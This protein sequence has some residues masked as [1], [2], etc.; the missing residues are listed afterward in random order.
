MPPNLPD[1][2]GTAKLTPSASSDRK[3]AF[4]AL[5]YRERRRGQLDFSGLGDINLETVLAAIA[6]VSTAIA[7]LVDRYV[8]RRT[9]LVYRVQV[10]ARIGVYPGT[11]KTHR[12]V[13]VE[14]RHQGVVVEDPSIVLLR[15]DNAG[16]MDI[17]SHDMH[18]KVAFAFPDR[19]IVGL[20]VTEAKPKSLGEMLQRR[21]VPDHY[22]DTSKLV[23]PPIAINRGDHFKFL[24]VL[25][26]T[27][28]GVTHSGYLAGGSTGGGVYHEPRPRGPGRRTLIFGALSLVL[29]GA[30]VAFFLV[31]VL[32]KSLERRVGESERW[33]V[34]RNGLRLPW[35]CR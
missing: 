10:D 6:L 30:L 11:D 24:L 1:G 25:S 9:R 27:G 13:D 29:V 3:H 17:D 18:E 20:K 22:V 2:L 19:K 31:D 8:L 34:V 7:W 15:L 32:S 5:T 23:V 14:V 16:G 26:G 33:N 12:M 28:K 4:T 35:R 21:L